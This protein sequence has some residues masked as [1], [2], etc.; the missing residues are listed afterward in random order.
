[1]KWYAIILKRF[2]KMFLAGGLSSALVT[3]AA[4]PMASDLD[5]K[6]WLVVLLTAF[7]TGGLA[8]LE[9]WSQGYNPQ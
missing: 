1:M 8:A 2:G 5:L 7:I 9:K 3:M 4:H 6:S